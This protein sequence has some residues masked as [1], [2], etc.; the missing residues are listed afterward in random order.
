[1][2]KAR[3]KLLIRSRAFENFVPEF[4]VMTEPIVT[5]PNCQSNIR[6][7]ESLAAPLVQATR[8]Q[9]EREM[10]DKDREIASREAAIRDQQRALEN[11]KAAIDQQ[12]AEK[13][14]AER[15]RIADE[16]MAKARRLAAADLDQK[17]KELA[18][19]QGVLKQRE[20]KLAEAQ[21]AQAEVM[22]KER[23]LDDAKRELDLTIEKRVQGSLT[24]VR[25]KAKH[26][27]EEG[28]KLR[29]LEKE[30]QIASMQRQ[31]EDL[32]RKAEQG[33]QQLQGEVL[34]LELEATLRSKFPHDLIEPVPKGEFGGDVL[35]R[36]AGPLGQP[37]GTILWETK[38]TKNWTDGWLAKL[39]EDQRKAKADIALIV[40]NAL[41]KGVH[42]FDH[43]DGVWVTESR[44]AVPIAIVLR[45]SLIEIAAARQASDGQQTKMEL[46]YHYL[47]GPRFRQRIEAIVEKFS[48]MQGDLDKE[49]R[50]LTRLWARREAQFRGVLEATA[51]M[52]GDLQGIAGKAFEE[53]DG[54]ALPMLEDGVRGG[55]ED[56]PIAA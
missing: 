54:I 49:R 40:S 2:P 29:V 6:L 43:V 32:K 15:K 27:A 31:I 22:R 42:T 56:E 4:A 33:S 7:T 51:G 3:L 5:C 20:Q 18:D 23:E 26:D 25:E 48:D 21:K 38:R 41:P 35:Q 19:L 45:Q 39:R 8:Q 50:A 37:C 12:I 53:I 30:E 16:E 55:D 17:S 34:E 46:V 24:A 28:L 13:L 1:M 9:F 52:Y 14:I 11:D 47:T 44:C 36:V 10:A